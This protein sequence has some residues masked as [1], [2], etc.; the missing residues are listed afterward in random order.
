MEECLERKSVS[1]NMQIWVDNSEIWIRLNRQYIACYF[2]D[3][4]IE[5]KDRRTKYLKSIEVAERANI[6]VDVFRNI[7]IR[8]LG[9]PS[10]VVDGINK[11]EENEVERW[12]NQSQLNN[13]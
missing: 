10:K 4:K 5:V 12:L 11:F 13:S 3:G 7:C 1:G 2:V 8:G 9:P 6:S